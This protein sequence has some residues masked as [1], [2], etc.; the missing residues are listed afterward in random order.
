MS[1]KNNINLKYLQENNDGFER[2]TMN[3]LII[4]TKKA[5]K[6]TMIMELKRFKQ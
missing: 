2:N 3:F 4:L 6:N 5:L 1:N